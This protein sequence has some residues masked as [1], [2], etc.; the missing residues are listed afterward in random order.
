V[1]WLME[2]FVFD[3]N[4]QWRNTRSK[5]NGDRRQ[6]KKENASKYT[7]NKNVKSTSGLDNIKK[8]MQREKKSNS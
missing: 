4:R 5:Y 7:Y 8:W 3:V 6:Y 1:K 2:V